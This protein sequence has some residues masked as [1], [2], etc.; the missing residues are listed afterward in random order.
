MSGK[1]PP[2]TQTLK[3]FL[4]FF[5]VIQTTGSLD[6]SGKGSLD[7]QDLKEA[8]KRNDVEHVL[9]T[10]KEVKERYPGVDL[11]SDYEASHKTDI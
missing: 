6:F 9:L 1:E 7:L 3:L 8:C 10:P 2:H 11:P 4:S 5:Q